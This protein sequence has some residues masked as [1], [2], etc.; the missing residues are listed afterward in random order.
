MPAIAPRARAIAPCA[1]SI[2]NS[3]RVPRIATTR[4]T[5]VPPAIGARAT[6]AAPVDEPRAD[7]WTNA[8]APAHGA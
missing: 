8:P 1:P 2:A 7:A 5:R 3:A 6:L 4:P